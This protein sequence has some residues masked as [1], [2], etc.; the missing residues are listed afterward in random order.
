MDKISCG[1]DESQRRE[2]RKL[3]LDL[4]A[5]VSEALDNPRTVEVLLNADGTL[6]EEPLGEPMQSIGA[7]PAF[8]AE[9]LIRCVAA[10]LKTTVT[11]DNPILE[12]ELPDGSRFSAQLP[13]V[14]PA[15]V[16]S[17][18]KRAS[19]V[20][21]LADYVV[22]GIMTLGQMETL[23]EAVRDHRNLLIS[24][25]TGSGKS[26]LG[27]AILAEITRQFPDERVLVI[28]DTVELQLSSPNCLQYRTSETVDMRRLL[29][30]TLR[31]R[32]DRVIV[33][34][35][36]GPEALNLLLSWNLGHPGGLA[37]VHANSARA[38]LPRLEMLVSMNPEAPRAIE[39][40][41]AEVQPVIAHIERASG[42]R[43]LR[44]IIE[45]QDYTKDGY[46]L[47]AL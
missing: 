19:A 25:G 6:W 21:P 44:E 47:R 9:S 43:R 13:P 5:V 32:P 17:I 42:G 18:R 4:G 16:F 14:V 35:V 26:T 7:M 38:A 10:I 3:R 29:R 1:A 40:F 46:Q 45:V 22:R 2:L 37:T 8:Q 31:M 11:R 15:P 36:R 33:G 27:N 41:I 34:E 30:T 12:G 23:V 20:F 28:E 24:G 39:P